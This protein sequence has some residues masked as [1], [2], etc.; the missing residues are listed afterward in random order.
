[1]RIKVDDP[2]SGHVAL[3]DVDDI[4]RCKVLTNEVPAVLIDNWLVVEYGL[5]PR[6]HGYP[7]ANYWE[8]EV[9]LES[10]TPGL[11]PAGAAIVNYGQ[12]GDGYVKLTSD[13]ADAP[14]IDIATHAGAPWTTITTHVRVGN[15][16]GVLSL[17]EEWGMAAGTDLSNDTL[18]HIIMSDQQVGLFGV[19]QSWWNLGGNV[20][21]QV[22]PTAENDED[23]FWLGASAADKRFQV[24]ADG[25]VIIEGD[26]TCALGD[27]VLDDDGITIIGGDGYVSLVNWFIDGGFTGSVGHYR[28][29]T[30]GAMRV[31][32]IITDRTAR[33]ELVAVGDD[34][35]ATL[36]VTSAESHA[37]INGDFRVLHGLYVGALDV[38][39]S[40]NNAYI[41]G[42]CSALTFTDRTPHY[43]GDAVAA[44]RGIRADAEGL[45][46]HATLPPEARR[47]VHLVRDGEDIYE[48]GRDLGAMVSILTVAVQEMAARIEKLEAH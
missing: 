18:P 37:S 2:P 48:E 43:K 41:V 35:S 34:G 23:V 29:A 36:S 11:L 3:F 9:T 14:F 20:I 1:M 28:E 46:D 33:T 44:L 13:E 39:P 19:T 47:T 7:D 15:L 8:Y 6:A 12:A 4:L 5:D 40:N 42:D 24:T 32:E 21:G 45:V 31:V 30:Y 16:D 22:I 10:G 25:D 38:N 27:V 26:L 17:G